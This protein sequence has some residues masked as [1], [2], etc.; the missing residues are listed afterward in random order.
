MENILKFTQ[1]ELSH[2]FNNHVQY[3]IV[4]AVSSLRII[5]NHLKIIN[6]VIFILLQL[7]LSTSFFTMSLG[8]FKYCVH[9]NLSLFK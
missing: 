9:G 5:P 6:L 2:N 1:G 8:H 4:L 7:G 3:L